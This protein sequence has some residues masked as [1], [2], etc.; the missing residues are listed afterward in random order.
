MNPAQRPSSPRSYRRWRLR[1]FSP[2]SALLAGLGALAI[3]SVALA[4]NKDAPEPVPAESSSPAAPQ[5][6]PA[7]QSSPTASGG[8]ELVG[9]GPGVGGGSASQQL[10]DLIVRLDAAEPDQPTTA[11]LVVELRRLGALQNGPRRRAAAI[12]LQTRVSGLV[13]SSQL[14]ARAAESAKPVL[15]HVA[16]PDRLVDLVQ[17]LEVD[18]SVA[19]PQGRQLGRRLYALDHRLRGGTIAAEAAALLEVL[20]G[21][22]ARGGVPE[23]FGTAAAPILQELARPEP[24][25]AL[26]A[27]IADL[28]RTPAAAGPG[29]ADLLPELRRLQQLPVYRRTAQ[30]RELLL[31][32]QTSADRGRLAAH[33]LDRAV[34][35][36][37]SLDD[38]VAT[39]S[40]V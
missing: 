9:S 39:P 27:L 15:E 23:S 13:A 8:G 5:S 6:T 17:L 35:V 20:R 40:A 34:R 38:S 21:G 16:E 29:A 11:A 7:D 3:A 12:A 31:T 24:A 2:A 25:A 36:L 18:P 33:F 14:D 28:Q 32:V 1:Q 19:G 30:S 26:A 22:P 10:R 4:L 37:S